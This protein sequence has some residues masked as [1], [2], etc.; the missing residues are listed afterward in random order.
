MSYFCTG[1]VQL[2]ENSWMKH[3]FGMIKTLKISLNRFGGI[4]M[5]SV[6]TVELIE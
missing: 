4:I 2:G 6:G 5:K 1:P 3:Y